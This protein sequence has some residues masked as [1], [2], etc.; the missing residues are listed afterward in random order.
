MNII[1]KIRFFVMVGVLSYLSPF[2]SHLLCAQTV[3]NIMVSQDMAYTDH[4]SLDGGL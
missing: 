3:K 1:S 2:T 4:I